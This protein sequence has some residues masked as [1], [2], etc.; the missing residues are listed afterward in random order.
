MDFRLVDLVTN[1]GPVKLDE[2]K[3]RALRGT[4]E[5]RAIKKIWHKQ[6]DQYDKQ[7]RLTATKNEY[8]IECESP[9]QAA[10]T[11]ARILGLDAG[12]AADRQALAKAAL[13]E[14]LPKLPTETL[15]AL[16]LAILEH[17][18]SLMGGA[19][20]PEADGNGSHPS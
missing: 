5:G 1:E 18:S 8:E 16:N 15:R 12:D 6:T 2:E 17:G 19:P 10:Q 20:E 7:G 9:L 14:L 13:A 11:M 3:I 4:E